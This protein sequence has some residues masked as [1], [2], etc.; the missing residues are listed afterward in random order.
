MA[1]RKLSL[2]VQ[3]MS[4][5]SQLSEADRLHFAD[6]I[7]SQQPPRTSGKKATTVKVSAR[8]D[9][10][11]VKQ[12]RENTGA[13]TAHCKQ[14]LIDANGEVNTAEILIRKRN[15]AVVADSEAEQP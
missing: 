10:L 4:N 13:T 6:F 12:L 9:G 7:R 15:Q 11:A 3:M 2:L 8:V 5:Y 1:K 14:A